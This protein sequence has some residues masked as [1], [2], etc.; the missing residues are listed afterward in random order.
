VHL[1]LLAPEE[2]T[3]ETAGAR[4]RTGEMRTRAI[5]L[6]RLWKTPRPPRAYLVQRWNE[7]PGVPQRV[8]DLARWGVLLA[9]IASLAGIAYR[10]GLRVWNR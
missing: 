3:P 7:L 2:A 10:G 8:A 1:E 9:L 6:E 4:R 5:S